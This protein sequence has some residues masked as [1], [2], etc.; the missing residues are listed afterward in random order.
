MIEL[1]HGYTLADLHQMT[2]AALKADR[3][4]AMDYHDRRD[5]AWS[6]IVEALYAA[7]H[8]PQR[9]TLIRAGWQA[10]YDEV[11]A[12][13]RHAGYRDR[14]WDTGVGTAARF[15]TY[16]AGLG[17]VTHS[18]EE[19]IVERVAL[20]AILDVLSPAERE[21][22]AALA[23]RDGD[24]DRAAADLGI[25]LAA[26]NR[27]LQVGRRRCLALWLEGETPHRVA[28]R[29]PDRRSHRGDVAECG[30]TAAARRHRS[31]RERLCELCAPMEADYDRQ[32]RARKREEGQ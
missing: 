13:R 32:R 5:I 31:R 6:A 19:R 18:P 3:S 9:H 22:L 28:L 23:A 4:M 2:A 17:G 7:P 24:R 27:R 25:T 20:P 8:W 30:T 10:I 29:R 21:A 12:N 15:A 26:F 14:E 16:W 1:R 11:R